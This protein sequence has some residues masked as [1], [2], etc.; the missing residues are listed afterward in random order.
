MISVIVPTYNEKENIRKL[1]PAVHKILSGHEHE[2]IVVDDNSPDGTAEVVEELSKDYPV[3]VLRRSGKLG[4]ASAVLHGFKHAK[5]DFLGVIDADLQHPPECMEG[6][7][8]AVMNGHDIAVGSRYVNGGSLEGWSKFRSLV[9]KGAILL[10]RPLT[11]VKDPM[12]GF[13][14]IKRNVIEGVSFCPTGYKI[15]LEILAKGSYKNVKEVPYTFKVREHGKSKLDIWEFVN[16][17]K[18]LYHLYRY[19]LKRIL[20]EENSGVIKPENIAGW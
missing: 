9:S 10:S 18:L 4:L 16:Y 6:F 20:Y 11:D 14:F 5:G 7:V 1:V 13:F 3:R 17:L 12:S 2:L 19:R 8:C 15:L